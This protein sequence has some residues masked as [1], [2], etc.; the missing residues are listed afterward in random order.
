VPPWRCR[1][2]QMAVWTCFKGG[3]GSRVKLRAA[4]AEP[5][6][7]RPPRRAIRGTLMRCQ[8]PGPVLARPTI[9]LKSSQI[10]PAA[11]RRVVSGIST[12]RC[13]APDFR[14]AHVQPGDVFVCLPGY[15]TG[16]D[17]RRA[18]RHDSFPCSGAWAKPVVRLVPSFPGRVRRCAS[19]IAGAL[20]RRWPAILHHPPP[21]HR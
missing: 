9:P 19:S 14:F 2:G 13:R 5:P 17:E 15:R 3:P 20:S 8:T 10:W 12:S 18:D 21:A 16:E 4:P 7:Q 11:F 6:A 1:S